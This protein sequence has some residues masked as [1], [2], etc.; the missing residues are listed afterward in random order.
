[1]SAETYQGNPCKRGHSGMRYVSTGN[2]VECAIYRAHGRPLPPIVTP[3]VPSRRPVELIAIVSRAESNRHVSVAVT[4]ST[5]EG[6]RREVFDASETPDGL[7]TT[8]REIADWLERDYVRDAA[9][10]A[11]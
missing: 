7:V 6:F 2:C 4:I 5:S 9:E 11:A 8:L 1:M 3:P 10:E